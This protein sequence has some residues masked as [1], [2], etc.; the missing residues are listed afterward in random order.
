[1][2]SVVLENDT[3]RMLKYAEAVI[4]ARAADGTRMTTSLDQGSDASCCAIVNLPAGEQY[5][6]YL[7][8]G[9]DAD[10][11]RVTVSYRDVSWGPANDDTVPPAL[12]AQSVALRHRA[13]GS[14][15][16]ADLTSDTDVPEAV[17]QAFVTDAAGRL[18][19]VVSGRWRCLAEGTRRVYLQLF[20]PLPD[21]A[22]VGRVV[23]HPVTDDPTKRKPDCG[24][25]AGP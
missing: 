3:D 11:A 16:I 13:D 17:V 24:D 10:V 2:L 18:L 20:H 12:T 9:T 22:R 25:P 19:V 21:D 4:E 8:V 15:V 5:G 6:L 1:L 14:V 7:D 23:A